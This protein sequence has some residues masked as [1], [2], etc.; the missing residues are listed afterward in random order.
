MSDWR[1]PFPKFGAGL[2]LH[3]VAAIAEALNLDLAGFGECGCVITG[4]NGK[5]SVAA[6]AASILTAS[7]ARVGR[8]TSPHLLSICERFAINGADIAAD[9]LTRHWRRIEAAAE[10]YMRAAPGDQLGGFEFLFLV[11]ASWFAEQGCT[12]TVWEAG[13]GGRYDP[14]RLVRPRRAALV[15]L[16]LEHTALLGDTLELIAFDKLD[17][18]PP[19]ARVFIGESAHPLR[20][21]I[22][23]YCALRDLAPIYPAASSAFAPPLAGPH[24]VNNTAI[25]VAL[26][27]DMAALAPGAIEAGLAATRWPGRLET[28]SRDPPI[29]IDVGHTPEAIRLARA[30]FDAMHAPAVLVCGASRDKPAD[31]IL[32]HLAPGFRTIVCTEARH[33]GRRAAEIADLARR[34]N[35]AAEIVS[36]GPVRQAYQAA[37]RIAGSAPIYVAGGLFL[38]AEFK[39][40]HIGEDPDALYFF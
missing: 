40:A 29:V 25:A 30:G 10:A 31:A 38:A 24:Q 35:P 15:S 28:I 2:G 12:H 39:A 27:A 17:A 1:V 16:D 13:I 14:T 4:S 21:R 22:G 6:M 19:G 3:R 18:A 37:R 36:A 9:D 32:A 5:G 7:G 33:K 34:A 11:A 20:A 8:F 23:A 26:A